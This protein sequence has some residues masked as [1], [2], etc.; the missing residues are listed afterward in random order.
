MVQYEY[1][2]YGKI[3]SITGSLANTV[4]VYNPFRYKGY[5]YDKET[6]MYYCNSRYYVPEWC[7]WL[8]IDSVEYLEPGSVNGLN[9]FAYCSNN[10][11]NMVDP[12]GHSFLAA[13]LI[14][15]GVAAL[16]GG[17]TSGLHAY[18]SGEREW[19]LIA[20]IAGGTIFGSAIGAT[21]ALGS[22]A[23]LAA[24]GASVAGFGIST[25]TALSISIGITATAGMAKYSL[26]CVDSQE[27]KWNLSGFLLSGI[28]GGLQGTVTFGLAFIG[29]KS[30]LFNKLGNFKTA[31]AFFLNYGGM[32]ILRAV[33][34]ASKIVIGETLSKAIFVS[35]TAAVARWI[36]DLLIPN[37]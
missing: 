30:G 24:T 11:V 2:A 6:N 33:F 29:G 27:Q 22:A 8:T 1:T 35:G 5:Y 4:G 31:D 36:I 23:G 7:R 13:L 34:W 18:K 9:L 32:N 19:D 26:N 37:L 12:S 14:S 16:I 21:I 25:G 28:E 15:M 3:S 20:D 17:V 10:P